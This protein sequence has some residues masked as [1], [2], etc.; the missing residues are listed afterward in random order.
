MSVQDCAPALDSYTSLI[1]TAGRQAVAFRVQHTDPQA[2]QLFYPV[3]E[4]AGLDL[5]R[6][7]GKQLTAAA[8]TTARGQEGRL[9][10]N[11]QVAS[12][13]RHQQAAA[14]SICQQGQTVANSMANNMAINTANKKGDNIA[15]DMAMLVKVMKVT[16]AMAAMMAMSM[17]NDMAAVMAMDNNM[18]TTMASPQIGPAK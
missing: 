15:N 12:S 18:A 17:A 11:W 4:S 2:N 8:A 9:E 16:K 14:G 10:T 13:S 6:R 5:N 3:R 1:Q 7:R